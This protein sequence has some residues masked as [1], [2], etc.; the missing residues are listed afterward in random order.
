MIIITGPGR[1]GTSFLAKLYQELGF[2]PGGRWEPYHNAGLEHPQVVALN[3]RI[4]LAMGVGIRERRGNRVLEGLGA[5]V[6]AS[7][8]RVSP[9]IRRPFVNAV[10]FF[11][12]RSCAPDLLD[13]DSIERVAAENGDQMRS[14]AK[15]LQIVKD[16]RFCFTLRAWL[17]AGVPVEA[18]VLNIR[19]LQAM[20]DSRVR[21]KM[22]SARARAWAKHNYAYGTGL[23][24][25]A[26]IE[27]RLPLSIL[28]YPDFLEDPDELYGQLPFPEPRSMDDFHHAFEAI[29]DPSLV[30]DKR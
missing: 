6:R 17:A 5:V 30:H 14:I 21:A 12:Y 18:V 10:D 2:D 23:L 4:A 16:P 29:L 1:S 3:N 19:P 27:H 25:T 24:L 9:R 7:E 15:E 26:V 13:F 22:F 20:A 8:G 28:R 11:R